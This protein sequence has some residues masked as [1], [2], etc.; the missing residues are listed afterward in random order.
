MATTSPDLG[1]GRATA[2]YIGAL[3][4]P[5]L[6]LLP[7]LA[8]SLAG[9]ASVLAWLGL[10]A[11]SGLL[12]WVFSSLGARFPGRG[13]AA[14]YAAAGLG[15]RAGRA[16]AWCFVAGVVLGAPV[17]C[18]IGGAYVAE[19]V[20]GGRNRTV[21]VAA[22]LLLVVVALTLG[23]A[24]TTTGAQL[25]LVAVLVVLVA[26]AVAGSAPHARLA[27][28]HPFA[29][30]GWSSIGSAASVLMLSFVGWEAIAPLTARLRNPGRQ[31]PR[32]IGAAF[33]VTSTV[34]LALS[35]A[36]VA[37]LGPHAGG[38][39]P[40]AA[41]LRLAIGPLGTFV[42]A[43]A[44]IALT[45]A[46]TNAYLSGAGELLAE[47]RE[48]RGAEPARAGRLQAGIAVT[49]MVL[50]AAVAAHLVS[51]VQLVALPTTLFL[52]VYLGC[53]ISAAKILTGPARVA[54][55]ASVLAVTVV[56]GFS[57]WALLVAPA[58]VLA[59]VLA[60]S[61]ARVRRVTGVTDSVA[62]DCVRLGI[63]C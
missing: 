33:A 35:V 19:L 10:L 25:A 22:V 29:P 43:L 7:G 55:A 28:W 53:T 60:A 45:L 32:V 48:H 3:L 52:T 17:V 59:S 36:T 9:P 24:R 50:L 20:G 12:A 39:V 8:A 62:S 16:V 6:L 44:A 46:A 18:L 41:L 61:A 1:T 15:D 38:A 13:G 40:L 63:R 4:G 21:L 56:L 2:L 27:N 37:V 49:G 47:L 54:A 5:G 11:V 34:Y 23:G 26:L 51:T 30:H 58:V 31:L 42:A 14:G 57:G